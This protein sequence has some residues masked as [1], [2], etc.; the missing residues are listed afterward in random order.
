M[1]ANWISPNINSGSGNGTVSVSAESNNT[2]RNP[3]ST[4][5]TFK[6]SGCADIVR[7]VNQ[8][9]KPEFVTIE[10]AKSV[11]KNGGSAITV[12]GTSNSKK[13]TF[14]LGNG[15]TLQL[16]LPASY[17]ANSVATNN[18]ADIA[19]D[20]GATQEYNFSITFVDP[21]ANST[22][23]ALTAQLIVT[24]DGGQTATCTITQAEGDPTL[25][26][27]PASVSL[28]WN[29]C[30]EGDSAAFTVTSNTNWAVE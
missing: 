18:G 25:N 14:A 22:I 20:P 15:N 8:A 27:S 21:D 11:G 2:G 17:I 26:V 23:N 7:T 4:N 5:L 16:Q 9:G 12:M 30:T 3:R 29:A 19:G 24:A 6:A 13:L 1:H 28:A 10:S